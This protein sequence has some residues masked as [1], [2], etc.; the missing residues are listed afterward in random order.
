MFYWTAFTQF[1]ISCSQF[2]GVPSQKGCKFC[3]SYLPSVGESSF[4]S[5][6]QG[7]TFKSFLYRAKGKWRSTTVKLYIARP[8]IMPIK[9]NQLCSTKHC[10]TTQKNPDETLSLVQCTV[11][12]HPCANQPA[13]GG[14]RGGEVESERFH[15]VPVWLWIPCWSAAQKR[16]FRN[17]ALL[18]L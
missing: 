3:F 17:Q 18:L 5:S 9:W 13:S 16:R 11:T 10:K 4:K 12:S 2:D 7:F 14:V 8:H 15:Q 6:R 1:S